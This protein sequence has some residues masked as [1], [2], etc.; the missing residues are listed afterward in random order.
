MRFLEVQRFALAVGAVELVQEAFDGRSGLGV[1]P[2]S[3]RSQV[4]ALV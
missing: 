3:G 2:A 4:I 1:S